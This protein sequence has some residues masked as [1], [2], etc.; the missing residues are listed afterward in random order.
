M[1]YASGQTPAMNKNRLIKGST[2]GDGSPSGSPSAKG[3]LEAAF[4]KTRAPLHRFG[5]GGL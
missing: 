5:G 4:P 1:S 2:G 3:A